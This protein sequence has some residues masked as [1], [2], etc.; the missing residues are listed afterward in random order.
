MLW[1]LAGTYFFL[2]TKAKKK[3]LPVIAVSVPEKE[4][5]TATVRDCT[6]IQNSEVY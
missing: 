2:E 3:S 5:F 6:V 4:I 1:C